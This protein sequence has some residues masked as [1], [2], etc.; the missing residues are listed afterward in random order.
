MT[1]Y[2]LKPE[3]VSRL[4]RQGKRD[5][6]KINR[7]ELDELIARGEAYTQ[8][9]GAGIVQVA[10]PQA[11]PETRLSRK[12]RKRLRHSYGTSEPYSPPL[13]SA[14]QPPVSPRPRHAPTPAAPSN[15]IRA[16]KPPL[17]PI[18]LADGPPEPEL[19]PFLEE[20]PP[21]VAKPA[22][23]RRDVNATPCP[24]ARPEPWAR[25]RRSE[26]G[27]TPPVPGANL[28]VNTHIC[29]DVTPRRKRT[30]CRVCGCTTC[31]SGAAYCWHCGAEAARAFGVQKRRELEFETHAAEEL[32]D[33]LADELVA[34]KND[35]VRLPGRTLR[36]IDFSLLGIPVWL[37]ALMVVGL[38]VPIYLLWLVVSREP[39]PGK[40]VHGSSIEVKVA[41]RGPDFLEKG[42]M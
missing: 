10:P 9:T 14:P 12:E 38:S 41:N 17:G 37:W 36:A 34:I 31:S 16:S 42:P 21:P 19:Y 32:I 30:D 35:F 11:K 29:Q 40:Q 26:T 15:V 18:P 24:L 3:A 23:R 1:T 25:G 7:R 28:R 39:E 4:R 8:G 2:Q 33:V 6:D 22:P 20:P 5:E 13:R 27:P